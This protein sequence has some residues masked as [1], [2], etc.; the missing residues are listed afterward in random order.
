ML[1][2]GAEVADFFDEGI[3]EVGR[4]EALVAAY[5]CYEAVFAVFFEV[6]VEGFGD[7]VGV[8]NQ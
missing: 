6:V 5:G 8:D 7:A 3:Q 4:R 1:F 2:V